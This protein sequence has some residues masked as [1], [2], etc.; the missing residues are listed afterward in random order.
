[1][2]DSNVFPPSL[3]LRFFR[4]Y[5]HP[6]MRDYI[7]GD[8]IEV[9]KR[10]VKQTNK[11]AADIRFIIDVLLLFRPGIIRPINGSR[12]LN[13]YSMIKN[14]FKTGWRNI[15][16]NKSYAAI[17]VAG[18]AVSM[19]CGILIFS[20]VKYHLS[21][22]NF[23]ANQNRLYRI[24]TEKHRDVISYDNSVPS[25]LGENFRNDYTLAEKVAR[26]YTAYNPLITIKKNDEIA[27]FRE[28]GG[29]AFAE[30]GFFEMFNFPLWTGSKQNILSEPRTALV[31]KRIARKYFGDKDPLGE[32]LWL[33]NETAFTI[34]GVLHDLPENTDI[35]SEI[36]VSYS[37]LQFHDRWLAHETAGWGGIRNGMQCYTLLKPGVTP[38]EVEQVLQPYVKKFRPNSKNVHHYKLQPLSDI[39][40]NGQYGGTMEKRKLWTMAVIGVFLLVTAC[41]NF[42]NLATAQ[43]LRRSK[44]VGVR[45]VLGSFKRQLFW[46]FIAETALV[47]V[48]GVVAAL[49]L[50][51]LIAPTANDLFNIQIPLNFISDKYTLLFIPVLA[52]IITL[53]AGYYPAI[54][55][56]G[57]KPV[58]ALKGR[59]SQQ[60]IGGFNT[61]RVL[62]VG[63]FI[64]SQ[65]LIIGMIIIMEQMRFTQQA[66]LGFEK[67]AIVM[68]NTGSDSTGTKSAFLKNEISRLPGVERVSLCFTPPASAEDWGNSIRFDNSDEEVNFRT[69][70]KM[71][72]ADYVSTFNLELVAGKDL[73]P[74]DTVREMLVNETLVRK[75]GLRSPDEIIGKIITADGGDMVAPVV[76][77]LK[78]FHDKSF[79]EDISPILL[80]TLS[81]NYSAYAVKMNLDQ[82]RPTIAE[83]EKIWLSQHPDQLFEYDFLDDQIAQFYQAEE[84]ILKSVQVF[85]IIAI[86]IGCLG[87]YGLI[88]FMATQ[89]TKEIG[90]RK[91]LGG[92]VTHIAIL[93]GREFVQL[94]LAAAIIAIPVG[95]WLMNNW[96]QEFK[97]QVPITADT[98]ILAIACTIVISLCTVSYQV[99]KSALTNPVKSLRSE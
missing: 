31:T 35:R 27:K 86:F 60:S 11:R 37:S 63:Q 32:V 29:L 2:K 84:T 94:I 21:F 36:F 88:S 58:S 40:F 12:N 10:R 3:F 25:P 81:E 45:K 42:I 54:I 61:R 57:F 43:A 95:W 38:A 30:A 56:S 99:F 24:V 47:V 15:I 7:E 93:F 75:L 26:V 72:D 85:S 41:V 19:T 1:M 46:Q 65:V 77:V 53:L 76:G 90:I 87:L 67:N 82:A 9:Y 8:L 80:T 52:V 98:F 17:N 48:L 39:H 97:F 91:I 50:A 78:D 18:L 83:I 16:R 55:L 23:H 6:G 14:Y 20:L 96:L 49:A 66:D 71:A 13:N 5:C 73:S 92:S 69:S 70:I 22:D 89:K 28:L 33:E 34:T 51:V 79:H 68:I 59:L 64:I 4:W 74:S 62:I 44:E